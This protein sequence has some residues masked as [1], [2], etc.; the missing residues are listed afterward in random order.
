ML[1]TLIK[2]VVSRKIKKSLNLFKISGE[3]KPLIVIQRFRFCQFRNNLRFLN[4]HK[5]TL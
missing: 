4:F 1:M 2:R 3:I 5:R